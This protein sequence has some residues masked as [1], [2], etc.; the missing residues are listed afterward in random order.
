MPQGEYDLAGTIVGIVDRKKIVDGSKIDEGDV[1]IGM[2]SSGLHTNGYSLARKIVFEVAGLE[3]HD[4]MP[5]WAR[6][7]PRR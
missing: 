6:P 7:W 3:I 5:G 4:P 2:P 1:I